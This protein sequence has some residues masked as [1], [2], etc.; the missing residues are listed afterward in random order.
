MWFLH[1]ATVV[2]AS[3]AFDLVST[4]SDNSTS[5]V[6]VDDSFAGDLVSAASNDSS[7]FEEI[8]AALDNSWND[9]D[10]AVAAVIVD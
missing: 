2:D 5:V 7:D 1:S 4:A 8:A 3:D 10:V 6:E 9:D